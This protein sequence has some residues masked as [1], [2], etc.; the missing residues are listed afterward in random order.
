MPKPLPVTDEEGG[1]DTSDKGLHEE[2]L[3]RFKIAEEASADNRKLALEDMKFRAGEQW[4]DEIKKHR[5]QPGKERPCLVV[6]KLNQYVRQVVNDGR[7]NRPSVKV[8]PIDDDGDPDVA[9]ALQGLIRHICDR[10]RADQAFDTALE[11]AVVGGFG[12]IRVLTEYA[13]ENTFN[14]EI[15]VR[16]VRNPLSVLLDPNAQMADGSD[17]AYGFVIDELP[18]EKFKKQYPKAKFTDWVSDAGK[19]SDGWMSGENVRFVE[20]FYREETQ[21]T[22][23][24]LSDGTSATDEEYQ[25]ATAEL[26]IDVMPQI[27]ESREIPS[28]KVKWCRL[29]GAE[30]LEKN[31]WLGKYIPIIP[32]YGNEM[33]IDGKVIY[34]GLIRSAKDPQRLYN[35][36]RSAYAERVALAPKAPFIAAEGQIEGHEHEWESANTD[37]LSV[38]TY[39]PTSVD[40]SPVPP[41]QRQQASDIPE[42]F[43]RDMQLSEHDIQA[44]LGM[45]SASLGQQSNEKSGKAIMARQREGDTGTF[46]YQDNQAR[47][48][49]YLGLQLVD[50]APKVYD[51]RR[52]VRILGEDGDSTD[53]MIDPE[54]GRATEQ[55]G[56][57]KVYNLNVG[58]YDVS[59]AAGPSYTTKRMEAA[60]AMMQL[61]QANPAIFS[62]VGDLMVKNMDWPGADEMAKRMKLMLPPQ[63]A[64]AE[65]QEEGGLPPEVQQA[66]QQAQQQIQAA[67]AGIAERDQALQQ[68]QQELGALKADREAALRKAETDQF[69]AETARAK[70]MAEAQ[71]TPQDTQAI[72]TLKLEYEDRWKK[73]EA[74]T[75]VIVAEIGARQ[76][77]ETAGISAQ[78][79]S[80]QQPQMERQEPQESKTDTALALALQGFQEALTQLRQP[81]K[82]LR[83]VSGRVEGIQ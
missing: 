38:L 55:R 14:Q 8:R 61:T 20:Y 65:Q 49:G 63:I 29:S 79:A 74:E 30:I 44:A 72:E 41:P 22:L 9:E 25:A 52:L 11:H 35:F 56:S 58:K 57:M 1:E 13:H 67:E 15:V 81:R 42:G 37:N 33:D 76:A 40:G 34:S 78:A 31:A 48:I 12:Y 10:S 46:H 54:M 24:L 45:Y 5:S 26:G 19:Y 28:F 21:V 68:V 80:F 53:A 71:N 64:Q 36:S 17:A 47:A 69:N 62:I 6:D 82:I 59:V 70:A 73:L 32:V 51:S 4:P 7:Q 23:H 83:D 16:R 60:E 50:L 27:E 43:A 77:T 2:G 75:K 3:A 18:K 39:K 66:M